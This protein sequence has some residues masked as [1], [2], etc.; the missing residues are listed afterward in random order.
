MAVDIQEALER[1][2]QHEVNLLSVE[3]RIGTLQKEMKKKHGASSLEEARVLLDTMI[4]D[5]AIVER[6]FE[7]Q[8]DELEAMSQWND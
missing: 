4:E 6:K 2:R 1:L 8:L 7:K 5:L 3:D